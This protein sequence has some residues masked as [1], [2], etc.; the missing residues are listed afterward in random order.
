[1]ANY[2]YSFISCDEESYPSINNYCAGEELLG[3]GSIVYL[4]SDP[5]QYYTLQLNG[6]DICDCAKEINQNDFV[7][8][9]FSS[10]EEVGDLIN[11]RLRNC[12]TGEI[13]RVSVLA[14]SITIPQDDDIPPVYKLE[15]Y[16]CD[17][18]EYVGLAIK[19]PLSPEFEYVVVT[20]EFVDCEDCQEAV[21]TCA[22][23]ERT[24]A[25]ALRVQLPEESIPDRGFKECCFDNV[26]L[27]DPTSTKGERNDYTS[28]YFKK[29][30]PSDNCDFILHFD[31][32]TYAL[33]DS[34]YGAFWD[35]GDFTNADLTVYRLDWQKVL[36]VL[37]EGIYKI[38]KSVTVAGLPFSIDSNTYKLK[39]Y[40]TER[41]D[42]TIR[43]DCLMT[44]ELVHYGVNF[45]DTGYKTTLRIP[46]FFGK[47]DPKYI[48]DNVVKRDYS[49]EQISMSQENEY[50]LTVGKMPVCI[51]DELYDFMLFGDDLWIS[52]YNKHNH[53]YKYSVFNVELKDS[54]GAKYYENLRKAS[55]S[56]TFTD[57]K[58]NNKKI[59]C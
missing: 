24:I 55:G 39:K 19:L 6:I 28:F 15:N 58:K 29:Q 26:V 8:T 13:I 20:G 45:K 23:G 25:Y 32:N 44:G 34:T 47:R 48:Q 54:K 18:W 57:R 17:C 7:I 56:L 31:G 14:D 5:S 51:T 38:E 41:A 40:S 9:P 46:G 36:N 3:N 49:I 22:E 37:G 10:C 52:D 35:F 50:S 42:K 16:N 1:M 4:P 12:S 2:C 30:L 11:I 53:S 33:N 59:N 43:I 27:A 21:G